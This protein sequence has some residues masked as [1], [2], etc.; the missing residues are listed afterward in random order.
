MPVTTGGNIPLYYR[1]ANHTDFPEYLCAYKIDPS[2]GL[3]TGAM[4]FQYFATGTHVAG[5]S[6]AWRTPSEGVYLIKLMQDKNYSDDTTLITCYVFVKD[7]EYDNQI[8]MTST[9]AYVGTDVHFSYTS[10]FCGS[11]AR[12]WMFSNVT[13]NYP[14]ESGK[15]NIRWS[16][17]GTLTFNEPTQLGLWKADFWYNNRVTLFRL[18]FQMEP[19]Q[20]S[21]GGGGYGTPVIGDINNVWDDLADWLGFEPSIFKILIGAI[22]CVIMLFLP[23]MYTAAKTYKTQGAISIGTGF[24]YLTNPIIFMGLLVL[25]MLICYALGLFPIWIFLLLVIVIALIIV[26]KGYSIYGGFSNG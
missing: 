11:D 16:Y 4:V 8:E 17:K 25:G 6:Y 3:E 2:T 26:T 21:G 10:N 24:A 12:I 18:P 7:R 19:K 23:L 9:H 13:G 20:S 1:D 22:I 15:Y 14:H 5:G